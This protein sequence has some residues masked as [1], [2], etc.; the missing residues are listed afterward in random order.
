MYSI[1]SSGRSLAAADIACISSGTHVSS[2]YVRTPRP[3]NLSRPVV[4]VSP[5][6]ICTDVGNT[7]LL[8]LSFT[9][10]RCTRI[11]K[12]MDMCRSERMPLAALKICCVCDC[13]VSV[14]SKTEN[15]LIRVVHDITGTAQRLWKALL[16]GMRRRHSTR[17]TATGR[18]SSWSCWST[19]SSADQPCKCMGC[20]ESRGS[21]GTGSLCRGGTAG[22]TS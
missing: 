8:S 22:R 17:S 1:G 12:I 21:L 20:L 4:A 3:S 14:F 10:E 18:G 2:K 13:V 16:S 15:K 19:R 11:I 7:Y 5:E 9:S 6:D